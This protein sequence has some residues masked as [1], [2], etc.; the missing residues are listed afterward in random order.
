MN[1]S[2]SKTD[3]R[4]SKQNR[5]AVETKG[6]SHSHTNSKTNN[7]KEMKRKHRKSHFRSSNQNREPVKTERESHL[8]TNFKVKRK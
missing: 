7:W 5:K 2:K 3:F 4:N 1:D 8:H 6:D